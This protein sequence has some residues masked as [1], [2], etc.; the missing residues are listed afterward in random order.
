MKAQISAKMKEMKMAK[1]KKWR[2][3]SAAISAAKNRNSEIIAK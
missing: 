3:I 1:I 2:I